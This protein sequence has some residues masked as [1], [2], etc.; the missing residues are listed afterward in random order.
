MAKMGSPETSSL[1]TEALIRAHGANSSIISKLCMDCTKEL[2]L[3]EK[4]LCTIY[5]QRWVC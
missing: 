3:S 2:D 5:Y 1:A 4:D